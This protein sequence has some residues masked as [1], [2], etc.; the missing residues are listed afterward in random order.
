M[1]GTSERIEALRNLMMTERLSAYLIPSTDP[2]QSEYVPECW[3]RRAWVSRF[4]GSAGD[5]VVTMDKAGLWTDGRYF[6]QAEEQLSGS[7]IDL[8]RMGMPDVPKMEEFL[9]EELSRGDKVGIDPRLLSMERAK[10]LDGRLS[11]KGIS[12]RYVERNLVDE[13]WEDRPKLPSDPISILPTSIAGESMPDKLTR[14]RERMKKNNATS[15]ILTQLDAVAWTFNLRGSDVKYNPVFI[16]YAVIGPRRS[17]LF[18][19]LQKVNARMRKKLKRYVEIHD[20]RD[21]G[22]FL[23]GLGKQKGRIWTDEKVTNKWIELKLGEAKGLIRDRSPVVEFKSIKNDR[24]LK[25]FKKA[26]VHDGIAVCRFLRWLERSLRMGE[27]VTEL[28][29]ARKVEEFRAQNK[30][31]IG[32]SFSTIASFGEH[33]AIIHYEPT[34]ETN[35]PVGKGIFLLDSG[36]Q[37]LYGTTD[38][39]RTVTTGD[40]TEEQKDHFTRVLKGHIAIASLR[41]PKG[42]SGKQIDAFARRA[43]W[44]A[45]MNYNHGTGHGI[46]HYLNVHEGPMGIT[47]RDTG[48]PLA[49]GNVLSN[50]PG[51][52]KVGEY[53]MRIENVIVVVRD[54]EFST[55]DT[56]FLRFETITLAPI[57]RRLINVHLLT[58]EERK[59][60]NNYHRDV[61]HRLTRRLDP[62]TR[63]WLKDRTRRI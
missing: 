31:H 24:E 41:F 23:E 13:L 3:Q 12:F 47:P 25:G 50:E 61:Y 40:V 37:Y 56:T 9:I 57:D 52:Y 48:V 39:T 21:I 10:E 46:G 16:S 53:G 49:D 32:P 17:H 1:K 59:W 2:H 18:I 51:F 4:T 54:E 6:V 28:D 26:H 36:G 63:K 5:V 44:D 33:G 45:G 27:T 11:K 29:A 58:N 43:L 42:F 8:Y 34:E 22:M 30:D 55:E 20:Y 15:M 38:I 19:D 35:I 62:D 14:I 60:L 7:G